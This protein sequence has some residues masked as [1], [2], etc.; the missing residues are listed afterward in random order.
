METITSYKIILEKGQAKKPY[1][2]MNEREREEVSIY[3]WE[4]VKRRAALV[5]QIPVTRDTISKN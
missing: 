3:V 5:G 2:E 1:F 4:E